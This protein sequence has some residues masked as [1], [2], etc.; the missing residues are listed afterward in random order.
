M[1]S[2]TMLGWCIMQYERG[3]ATPVFLT[4][5][6]SSAPQRSVND[7]IIPPS[8]FTPKHVYAAVNA[9]LQTIAQ[10]I[11]RSNFGG[12]RLQAFGAQARHSSSPHP[13]W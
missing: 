1:V 10:A 2:E 11:V 12:T 13:S 6:H 5:F 7:A 3:D 8:G 9:A 4:N